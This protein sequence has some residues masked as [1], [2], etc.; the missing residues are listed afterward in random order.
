MTPENECSSTLTFKVGS[1]FF[2]TFRQSL[3]EMVLALNERFAHSCAVIG[4]HMGMTPYLMHK[5]LQI[6][7]FTF[8]HNSVASSAHW[9]GPH[10]I[11][12]KEKYNGS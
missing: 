7:R 10:L 9:N 4:K 1:K 8:F 11:Q 5:W 2:Q 3:V 12:L 6:H